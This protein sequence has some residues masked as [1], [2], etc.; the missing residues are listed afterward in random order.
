MNGNGCARYVYCVVRANDKLSLGNIGLD[1]NEVYTLPCD[2]LCAVAHT[3]S[4]APYSSDS[5][6]MVR[7]W[8]ISHQQVVKAA[9]NKFGAVLPMRFN[10]IIQD[11]VKDSADSNVLRWLADEGTELKKKLARLQD[12]EEYGVQIFWEPKVIA[13]MLSRTHPEIARLQA[14]IESKTLGLAYMNK[15]RLEKLLRQEVER[16]AECYF[17]DFYRRIRE[18]VAELKIEGIKRDGD[19]QMLMNLSC[20]VVIGGPQRLSD[21][22]QKI[23]NIDGFSVRFTGPWPPYSF[24]TG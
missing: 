8:V 22:L 19:K 23:E 5:E 4:K 9:Q 7:G 2:G 3:C 1:A 20:L 17:K 24:V 13:S 14:E 12:L 6:E 16:E 11:T 15:Q 10:T 18:N 21:E